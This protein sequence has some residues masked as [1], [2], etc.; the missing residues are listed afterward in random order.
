M[1]EVQ[2]GEMFRVEPGDMYNAVHQMLGEIDRRELEGDYWHLVTEARNALEDEEVSQDLVEDL[3]EA[4][5]AAGLPYVYFGVH[6][7]A[8]RVWGY[9]LDINE[10]REAAR[11]GRIL[12]VRNLEEAERK[13]SQHKHD[14]VLVVERAG[15]KPSFY[16]YNVLGRNRDGSLR[17]E[18]V[19]GPA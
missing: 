14:H 10:L 19:W 12:E 16:L 9:W 7:R 15:A 6:Q 8:N 17:V 4:L 13:Y 5:S 18:K 11:S 2:I 1:R 3:K